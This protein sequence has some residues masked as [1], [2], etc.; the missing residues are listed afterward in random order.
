MIFRKADESDND[1]IMKIIK[2]AQDYFK[3]NGID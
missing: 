2:Q 3:K 1:D